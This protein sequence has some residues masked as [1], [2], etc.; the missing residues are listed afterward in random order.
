MSVARSLNAHGVRVAAVVLEAASF[1]GEA[2]APRVVPALQSAGI[3]T[4]VL[5]AG[6]PLA[7]A[8]EALGR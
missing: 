3:L 6:K 4:A 2:T 7:A 5:E 1:G 8:L